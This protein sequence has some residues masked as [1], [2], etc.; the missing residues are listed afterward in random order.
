MHISQPHY[1]P[2]CSI[3]HWHWWINGT[4]A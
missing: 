4:P 1:W 2:K 3:Q